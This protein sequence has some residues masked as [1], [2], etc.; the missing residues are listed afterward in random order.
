MTDLDGER[1]GRARMKEVIEIIRGQMVDRSLNWSGVA[2]PNEGWAQQVYGEP[3]VERLWEAVAFCTRLDEADP[4]QAWRDHMARLEGAR[5]EA[6]RARARRDP[7]H[8]ARAP[9]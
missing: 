7:L 5:E 3:D 1:V 2:Y 4:V 8:A 9:T 6:E